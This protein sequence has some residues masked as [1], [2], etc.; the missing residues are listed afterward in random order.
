MGVAWWG[1]SGDC[2]MNCSD[3]SGGGGDTSCDIS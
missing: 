1:M 3:S 2:S